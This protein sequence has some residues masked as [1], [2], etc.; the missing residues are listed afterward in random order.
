LCGVPESV[1]KPV[2]IHTTIKEV[3]AGKVRSNASDRGARVRDETKPGYATRVSGSNVPAYQELS[4]RARVDLLFALVNTSNGVTVALLMPTLFSIGSTKSTEVAPE[5]LENAQVVGSIAMLRP[6]S[7]QNLSWQ[8]VTV[9]GEDQGVGEQIVVAG[10][11]CIVCDST[12]TAECAPGTFRPRMP[13]YIFSFQELQMALDCLWSRFDRNAVPS[14]TVTRGKALPYVDSDG[15]PITVAIGTENATPDE[16]GRAAQQRAAPITAAN[17]V[18]CRAISNCNAAFTR[19]KARHH[20]AKHIEFDRSELK[21][22][23]F[24]WPRCSLLCCAVH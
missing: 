22:S 7:G 14:I 13:K 24:V 19:D 3:F 4:I 20:A 18:T 21:S 6:Q 11:Q 1:G 15:L 16:A 9:D 10:E 17:K 2:S 12:L 23:F 8:P 5:R